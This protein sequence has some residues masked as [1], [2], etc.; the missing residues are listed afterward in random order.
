M[1]FKMRIQ[2]FYSFIKEILLY[3]LNLNSI[4]KNNLSNLLNNAHLILLKI[5][6]L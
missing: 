3:F 1:S 6:Y 2:L 4:P 5:I